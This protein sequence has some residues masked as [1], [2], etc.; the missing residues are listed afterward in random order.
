MI[1]KVFR[2]HCVFKPCPVYTP[3]PKTGHYISKYCI[4]MDT[5]TLVPRKCTFPK[6]V[7]VYSVIGYKRKNYFIQSQKWTCTVRA[8]K[9][10]FSII[11]EDALRPRQKQK[12]SE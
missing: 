2:F 12:Y 11:K 1:Y 10:F 3:E 7:I 5:Y 6:N 9:Y 4:K 8:E